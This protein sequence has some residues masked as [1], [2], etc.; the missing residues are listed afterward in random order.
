MGVTPVFVC[1]ECGAKIVACPESID[2]TIEELEAEGCP[3]CGGGD[4]EVDY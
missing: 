3:E 4:I 2:E 1:L